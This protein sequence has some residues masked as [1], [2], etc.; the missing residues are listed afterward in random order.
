[1]DKVQLFAQLLALWDAG[2]EHHLQGE[3][4]EVISAY[5]FEHSDI[6]ERNL[7]LRRFRRL[8]LPTRREGGV[9]LFGVVSGGDGARV[10]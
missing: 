4:V 10:A 2:E 1:V 3:Q 9:T 8:E 7:L 6:L 5:N